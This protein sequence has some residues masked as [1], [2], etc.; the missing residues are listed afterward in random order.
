MELDQLLD[1]ATNLFS[2]VDVSNLYSFYSRNPTIRPTL[3]L[4]E[5]RDKNG[6]FGPEKIMS[7]EVP[8]SDEESDE[9]AAYPSVRQ[10]IEKI[11][12][13]EH[14]LITVFTHTG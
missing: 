14:T 2:K 12:D 8:S 4:F 6:C 1:L 7:L 11:M 10:V 9:E 13:S 3:S 5:Q